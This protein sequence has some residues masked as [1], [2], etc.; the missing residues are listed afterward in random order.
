MHATIQ[1][2]KEKLDNYPQ[3]KYEVEENSITVFPNQETGFPVSLCVAQNRFTV[4]FKGWHEELNNEEEALNC[5]R[6]G[7]SN[8]CRLKVL[9]K[10][11]FEYKWILEH[12]KENDW[13]QDSETGILIFPFWM[14]KS[15]SYF[16]NNYFTD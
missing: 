4:S 9:S 1:K 15:I 10:G 3:I 8:K 11:K 14:K 2:L 16:Q 12:K 5:F 6:F 13:L 7:L